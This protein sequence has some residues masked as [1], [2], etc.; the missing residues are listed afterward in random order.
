MGSIRS[1][2]SKRQKNARTK[3]MLFLCA[4]LVRTRRALCGYVSRISKRHLEE[5]PLKVSN[6]QLL[7]SSSVSLAGSA[8]GILAVGFVASN[9][10]LTLLVAPFGASAVLLFSVYDSPLAQPRSTFFG[11]LLSGFI[12]AVV[13]LTFNAYFADSDAGNINYVPIAISVSLS[14]FVM[15]AAQITHP[16]AGATAFLASTSVADAGSLWSF[17]FLVSTGALILIAIAIMFNNAIPNRRY[18]AYW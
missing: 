15:R 7:L 11:H 18:P 16:P 3:I 4:L 14:I 12:G 8:L 9:F 1:N 2:N 13:A 6:R 17:I 10:S 5:K